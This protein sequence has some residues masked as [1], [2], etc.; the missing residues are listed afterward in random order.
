MV[1][2]EALKLI[3]V[4][5]LARSESPSCSIFRALYF[6]LLRIWRPRGNARSRLNIPRI[7]TKTSRG[8][9]KGWYSRPNGQIRTFFGLDSPLTGETDGYLLTTLERLIGLLAASR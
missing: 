8:A 1:Q 4:A 3:R 6:K 2:A 9:S 5:D 7:V